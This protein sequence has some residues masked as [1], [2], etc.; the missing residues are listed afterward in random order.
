MTIVLDGDNVTINGKPVNEFK[1]DNVTVF[2]RDRSLAMTLPGIR[3]FGGE[4]PLLN[5]ENF[6]YSRPANSNKAMLGVLT[7]KAD[8]GVKVTDVTKEAE[9]RK[10]V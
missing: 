8:N 7:Q 3:R 4:H 1:D 5:S 6:N 9:L 10:L 2:K